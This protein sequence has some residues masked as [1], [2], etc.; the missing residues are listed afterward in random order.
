MKPD[1]SHAI[2][3]AAWAIVAATVIVAVIYCAYRTGYVRAYCESRYGADAQ[4]KQADVRPRL[5]R[6][7]QPTDTP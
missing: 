5:S 6:L 2:R 7:P 3:A 4:T 1:R